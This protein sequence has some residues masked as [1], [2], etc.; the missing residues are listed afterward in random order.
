MERVIVEV[1]LPATGR[2]YDVRLPL[3]MN[4]R[5]VSGMVA[6]ALADLSEGAYLAS[7]TSFLAWKDSGRLLDSHKTLRECAVKNTSQLMLI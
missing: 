6:K 7:P 5:A 4:V 2:K 1:F 3:D